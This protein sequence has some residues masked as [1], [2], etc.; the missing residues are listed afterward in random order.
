M[1]RKA[2]AIQARVAEFEAQEMWPMPVVPELRKGQV[3][4]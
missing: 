3:D 2:L 1:L 4:P